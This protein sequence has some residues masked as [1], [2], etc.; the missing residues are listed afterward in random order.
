MKLEDHQSSLD[1][2]ENNTENTEQFFESMKVEELKTYIRERGVPVSKYKKNDL[3]MLAKSLHEM[4][5][6]TDPDFE[7]DSIECC[8][9]ERLT[10]PAGKKVPDPFSGKLMLGS[11]HA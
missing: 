7:K 9:N 8:L 10:L 11:A 3:I 1:I 5:A 2:N 6:M 4:G